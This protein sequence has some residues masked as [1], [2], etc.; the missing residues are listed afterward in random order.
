MHAWI[1]W[2]VACV[3]GESQPDIV[4]KGEDKYVLIILMKKEG[5]ISW[6]Q[7]AEFEIWHRPTVAALI[8]DKNGGGGLNVIIL[9]LKEPVLK[10]T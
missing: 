7:E 3:A 10:R 2:G 9:K 4:Q 5:D 1:W 8:Q 6:R